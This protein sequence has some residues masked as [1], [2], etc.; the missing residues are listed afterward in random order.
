MSNA[1]QALPAVNLPALKS[2]ENRWVQLSS[3]ALAVLVHAT[4]AMGAPNTPAPRPQPIV[5][6]VDL[7]P[8]PAPPPPPVETPA[9][10]ESPTATVAPAL[11]P[12]AP[13]ASPAP[14]AARA[15]ALLTARDD[16]PKP[17]NSEAPVE[18]VTDPNGASYGGGVVA[19]GGTADIGEKGATAASSPTVTAPAAQIAPARKA[20][21]IVPPTDLSR[22]AKLSGD[23][24]CKGYFPSS[25]SVDSA[26][27]TLALVVRSSG[28][29][30][31]ASV[32]SETPAGQGFG[33]AA[34]SCMLSSRFAAALDRDGKSVTSATTLRVRFTR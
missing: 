4:L 8:L 14:M 27:V 5:T 18:F 30:A 16:A 34:R 21:D 10:V 32:V 11:A 2:P 29:V 20:D 13:I 9:P 31:S 23:D 26:V 19:R 12:K 24:A 3:L 25:A 15:G 17:Q 7:A 1:A 22:Q 33:A 28:Q 6:E